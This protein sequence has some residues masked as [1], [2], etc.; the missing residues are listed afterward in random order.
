V[1]TVHTEIP[2]VSPFPSP[3]LALLLQHILEYI[4][5]VNTR[6]DLFSR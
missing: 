3:Y 1:Y 5:I 2:T 4:S 6:P